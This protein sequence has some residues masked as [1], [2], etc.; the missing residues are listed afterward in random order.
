MK[1]DQSFSDQSFFFFNAN[2]LNN[3]ITKICSSFSCCSKL[4]PHVKLWKSSAK[5]TFFRAKKKKINELNTFAKR[6]SFIHLYKSLMR[7]GFPW[8][9]YEKDF[10]SLHYEKKIF[11][12]PQCLF[13]RDLEEFFFFFLNCKIFFFKN[14][15]LI[16]YFYTTA[17]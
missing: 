1:E 15:L 9:L 16:I 6:N 5:T 11:F 14:W 12:Q 8:K 17:T 4:C 13:R 10:I 3:S 2:F 7:I